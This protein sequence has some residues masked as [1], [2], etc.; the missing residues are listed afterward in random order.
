MNPI[1]L[2]RILAVLAALLPGLAFALPPA[3]F[4]LDPA[5]VPKVVVF[6]FK[7]DRAILEVTYS[8]EK[9][10]ELLALTTAKIRQPLVIS[11]GDSFVFERT[12]TAPATGHSLKFD[13]PT[14]SEA[15]FL[16][17]LLMETPASAPLSPPPPSA[18][19]GVSK[20]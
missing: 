2:R 8:K 4:R 13:V 17:R 16:A 14:H 9:Q 7:P 3:D 18:G 1:R 10:A 19:A 12:F 5:D 11:I 6:L 20:P 15:Q